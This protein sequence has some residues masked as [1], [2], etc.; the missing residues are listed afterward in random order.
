M[1]D[2]VH[3]VLSGDFNKKKALMFLITAIIN[4][5]GKILIRR[6]QHV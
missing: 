6:A 2:T 4:M 1:S 5:I 3:K